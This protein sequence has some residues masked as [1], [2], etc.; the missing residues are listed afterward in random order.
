[1]GQQT[2]KAVD[3]I[4]DKGNKTAS[5]HID[6]RKSKELVIGFCGAIGSGVNII[7]EMVSKDL[8]NKYNYKCFAIK[9]SRI[10]EEI[11]GCSSYKSQYERFKLLQ[12]NGNS[13]RKPRST[14]LAEY[15]IAQIRAIKGVTKDGTPDVA[16]ERRAF[17]V[18]QLKH[19][20]EIKLLKKVYGESFYLFGVLSTEHERQIRLTKIEK[21]SS[22][23]AAELL[24]RDEDDPVEYGQ[25]VRK[26]LQYA[27]FFLRHSRHRH[28]DCE[29]SAHRFISLMLGMPIIT[30]SIDEYAMY[31]A[32]TASL[33]SSCLSRQ[34]G[35]SIIDS[36]NH[37]IS[38]GYNDVPNFGGGLYGSRNDCQ[39]AGERCFEK[40]S[41]E[42]HNDFHKNEIYEEVVSKLCDEI[43]DKSKRTN[44]L[45]VLKKSRIRNL[46]EFS[47]SIHAE[48]EAILAA[49]RKGK[50]VVGSRLFCTTFPCHNCAR[51][52]IAA[53]IDKVFFIEP[54]EKSLA[55]DLHDDAM[56]IDEQSSEHVKLIPFEGVAPS[57]FSKLFL[58]NSERKKNGKMIEIACVE[59]IP[60]IEEYLDGKVDYE[61]L[62]LEYL[63]ADS[64]S[65]VEK[66]IKI[67]PE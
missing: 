47:R 20:D 34:V 50:T 49:G 24:K 10:I 7:S 51:H 21:L 42:C 48:M 22:A 62:M 2:I 18:D 65:E 4:A 39:K 52:I 27:D 30:P 29:K 63:S 56:S 15:T 45:Q 12:D 61:T 59:A 9:V 40:E 64:K 35:A 23:E 11:S 53:G 17:I 44:L 13:I 54:Y 43:N 41:K 55:I 32:Y 46:L 37:L 33:R 19:P 3:N 8:Q 6:S 1:M 14:K 67:V 57:K 60:Q 26:S 31:E 28:K 16:N 25:K 58:M 38:T 66:I 36:N 5:E